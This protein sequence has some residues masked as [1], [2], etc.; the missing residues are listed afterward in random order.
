MEY[1]HSIDSPE[2]LRQLPE[3]ALEDVV[4]ELR[5]YLL[6]STNISGGHLGAGLGVAE[7]TVALHYVY[8]TPDD[9]LIWDVGHQAYPHKILTGRKDRLRTIRQTNGV[10]PFPDRAESPFDAFTVG[11]SSTSIGAAL[12]MAWANQH[13]DAPEK[14][15]I[16]VIGDGGM[17]AGMAF[18]ALNHAGAQDT[19][20]LVILND[21]AMSIS[22]NVGALSN[23]LARILSSRL[24]ASM[25]EGSK[26]VLGRIPPVWEFARRTESH[27][28]GMVAPGTLFEELGFNYI[29]PIDG[30]DVLGLVRMLRNVQALKGP[31]L[32]HLVT[33]KGRGYSP[34]EGDPIAYHAVSPSFY[35]PKPNS[36]TPEK[37]PPSKGDSFSAV[38]GNWLCDVCHED[39]DIVG[40]TPAM[41]EGSGM[42]KFAERFPE[43]YVDVGIAEQHSIT[44]AAGLACEG[45]KP[46]VAIYSSFLQRAYDQL[47]HDVC[48]P[49]LPVV[50]AIDRA[51]LVPDGPTHN[52]VFDLSFLRAVPNLT[53]MAPANAKESRQMLSTAIQLKRPVAVRYPRGNSIEVPISAEDLKGLQ[54]MKAEIVREGQTV[55]FL[56]FGPLLY[57]ALK[58]AEQLDATVVNMRYVKPIDAEMI[59]HIAKTHSLL[60]SVEENTIIGGAGSA[61]M[62]VLHHNR[63]TNALL[64]IGL[65]DA[66]LPHGNPKDI[67]DSVGLNAEG[68]L[69]QTQ[70]KLSK[71]TDLSCNPA[72]LSV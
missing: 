42:V 15:N 3:S 69:K 32:L 38:F 8:N 62:E 14:S 35:K 21:N 56:A 34:A 47:I 22:A 40:I 4:K 11:H 7:L 55:A 65:P 46:V 63:L 70:E 1:L 67:Y 2:Q 9:N 45:K 29:G 6:Q 31:Q 54:S 12:G 37:K 36:E 13:S 58:V 41:R 44:F 19:N 25:R 53:I 23:Y 60:V 68:I 51:G 71:L 20:L 27:L 59:V 5:E 43:Q 72:P 18:E 28:K 33:Q 16:A 61:V 50:F 30:H 52:G 17:T 10:A 49:N 66:F 24:Y 64:T 26:K 57:E 48:L 39:A